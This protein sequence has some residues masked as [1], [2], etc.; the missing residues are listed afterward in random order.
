MSTL[1]DEVLYTL[2]GVQV[3]PTSAD[4]GSRKVS[5]SSIASMLFRGLGSP[6]DQL[7]IEGLAVISPTSMGSNVAGRVGSGAVISPYH[8]NVSKDDRNIQAS[9]LADNAFLVLIAA[10]RKRVAPDG[11]SHLGVCLSGGLDSCLLLLAAQEMRLNSEISELTAYHYAWPDILECDIEREIALDLCRA[12]GVEFHEIASPDL[13]L[14]DILAFYAT[15]P[16]PYPQ[17]FHMQLTMAGKYA[18]EMGVDTLMSGVGSE[19]HFAEPGPASHLPKS[20]Q[21]M[22]PIADT[23]SW[24]LAP[25][26]PEENSPEWTTALS[27]ELRDE[28]WYRTPSSTDSEVAIKEARLFSYH[29]TY[30]SLAHEH[31]LYSRMPGYPA[32][33]YPYMDYTFL[34]FSSSVPS[35]FNVFRCG[36]EVYNKGLVRLAMRGRAST[37][38][39]LRSS[40]APYEAVE[41]DYMRRS[42][43]ELVEFWREDSE[44]EGLGLIDAGEIRADLDCPRKVLRRSTFLLP[45]MLVESW[46]RFN[47][48]RVVVDN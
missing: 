44:L 47:S 24:N 1:P 19:L 6:L 10:I 18:K 25:P 26:Y 3:S 17:T 35:Y 40:G 34:R 39:S 31:F 36:G 20:R 14:L 11:S 7:P 2:D 16:F 27:R 45:A 46:L 32:L 33:R 41:Q 12:I 13:K 23:R 15:L 29:G 28:H 43:S 38:V 4:L 48:S 8:L 37:R 22:R 21:E 5:R 9:D 42:W 30:A